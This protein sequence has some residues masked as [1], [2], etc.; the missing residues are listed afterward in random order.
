MTPIDVS[1]EEPKSFCHFGTSVG[2]KY[3]VPTGDVFGLH[4]LDRIGCA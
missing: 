4:I 1:F 3:D 2:I